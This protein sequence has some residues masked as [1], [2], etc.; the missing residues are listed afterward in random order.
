MFDFDHDGE[1]ELA[2]IEPF[3]GTAL[4]IYKRTSSKWGLRY[5][6]PLSFGHG[7]SAGLFK[8]QPAIVVGNRRDSEA[9]EL[10]IVHDLM[11]SEI[12]KMIV[13]EHVG[14]TQTQIFRHNGTDYILSANQAKSEIALYD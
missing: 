5:R 6:S 8:N 12:E 11:K 7:L 9:L 10:H 13:E 14:P 1:D 4:N 3:H 2:T